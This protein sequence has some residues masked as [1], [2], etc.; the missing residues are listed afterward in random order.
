VASGQAERSTTTTGPSNHQLDS[1][2]TVWLGEKQLQEAQQVRDW[3]EGE[4]N[5]TNQVMGVVTEMDINGIGFGDPL[6]HSMQ[7][8]LSLLSFEASAD[9]K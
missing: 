2:H 7:A 6:L 5:A 8:M 4:H 1:L 9:F 3:A